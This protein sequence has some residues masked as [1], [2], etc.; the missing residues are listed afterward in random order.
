MSIRSPMLYFALNKV[1]SGAY[2]DC[3]LNDGSPNVGTENI[4]DSEIQNGLA[5]FSFKIAIK[6]LH[7]GGFLLTKF[8]ISKNFNIFIYLL[9][10]LFGCVVILKPNASRVRSSEVYVLNFNFFGLKKQRFLDIDR[11]SENKIAFKNLMTSKYKT[12]LFNSECP[13]EKIGRIFLRKMLLKK[14]LKMINQL[15]YSILLLL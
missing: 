2:Y 7:N 15:Q 14:D 3:L 1:S 13:Y 6:V 4:I 9:R 8:F 10:M 12:I 5:F 11:I